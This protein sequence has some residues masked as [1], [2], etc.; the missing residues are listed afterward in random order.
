M[1][2]MPIASTSQIFGNNETFEPYI[3]SIKTKKVLN[4][5]FKLINM[6]ILEELKNM[7]VI[8]DKCIYCLHPDCKFEGHKINK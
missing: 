5:E 4:G 2:Q 8:K 1:S 6:G 3:E 7:G